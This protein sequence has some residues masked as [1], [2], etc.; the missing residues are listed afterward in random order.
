M[1]TNG[2]E[3]LRGRGRSWI[4]TLGQAMQNN[5]LTTARHC[6]RWLATR[7][8]MASRCAVPRRGRPARRNTVAPE[9]R[10]ATHCT[11]AYS[12]RKCCLGTF[13]VQ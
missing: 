12:I 11:V 9:Y 3:T 2:P 10:R 5:T 1:E 7:A 13:P 6:P 4:L 8:V